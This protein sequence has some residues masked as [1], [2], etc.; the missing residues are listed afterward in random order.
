ML[1]C[2]ERT[3]R[4]GG[5]GWA[6]MF[7][8]RNGCIDFGRNK[9]SDH[10]DSG[11]SFLN[12]HISLLRM[13]IQ[14]VRVRVLLFYYIAHNLLISNIILKYPWEVSQI[15]HLTLVNGDRPPTVSRETFQRFYCR[16]HFWENWRQTCYGFLCCALQGHRTFCTFT[17][18]TERQGRI[19]IGT[20][21][22]PWTWCLNGATVS[23][24]L[25]RSSWNINSLFSFTLKNLYPSQQW[26][27]SDIC[28]LALKMK[29]KKKLWTGCWDVGMWQLRLCVSHHWEVT[30]APGPNRQRVRT[31]AQSWGCLPWHRDASV[32]VNTF[33]FP[34]I[35]EKPAGGAQLTYKLFILCVILSF[36]SIPVPMGGCSPGLCGLSKHMS[37]VNHHKT[38]ILGCSVCFHLW[39]IGK[40]HS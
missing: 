16:I 32:T 14:W 11:L 26:R 40:K 21:S 24:T 4:C 34:F 22:P 8:G 37:S 35:A 12:H 17:S 1:C 36:L 10:L 27:H 9:T 29:Q 2:C 38:Q 30:E 20:T 5:V 6:E 13:G 18:Y 15:L 39:I 25:G 19:L 31:G 3:I 7:C 33:Y 28:Q 23:H